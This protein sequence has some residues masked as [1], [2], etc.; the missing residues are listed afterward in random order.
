MSV[1]ETVGIVE[2]GEYQI[3]IS[4]LVVAGC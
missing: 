1:Q 2:S 3:V 4:G